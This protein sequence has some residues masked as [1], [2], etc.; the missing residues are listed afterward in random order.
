MSQK[1]LNI[2]DIQHFSLGDGPG[3]RTTV[4]F[5]SCNLRCP[6]CHNPETQTGERVVMYYPAAHK[7]VISG[8]MMSVD[9][10]TREVLA[11]VDFYRESHGGLTVSG[12]E[13]MLRPLDVYDLLTNV[14]NS[15][16]QNGIGPVHTAIDTA[17]CV[18][19]D[20]FI[21]VN[22][23]TDLYL[24][25]LKT[26]FKDKYA[27]IGG[28]LDLVVNNINRLTQ[29][30][31][32]VVIRIPLIP[33]FNTDAQSLNGLADICLNFPK[34]RVDLLP[35]HRLGSGKYKALDIEY[36]YKD[37]PSLSATESREMSLP[38]CERGLSVR[39]E[40]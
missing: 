16:A 9:E 4:F 6:W 8:S 7:T 20:N 38:F 30:E 27:A 10:I 1:L 12:G 13:C 40:K 39:I 36:A 2:S 18:P 15:A 22:P 26:P 35:F 29:D 14:Q 28:D 19:Y 11:D 33:G 32:Q 23:L 37:V 3:I 5:K 34:L 24:F 31:K 17:G 21:T 25:D